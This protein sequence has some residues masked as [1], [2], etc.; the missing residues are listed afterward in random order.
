E[1]KKSTIP[2]TLAKKPLFSYTDSTLIILS[3]DGPGLA[4]L[5]IF[6]ARVYLFIL[7]VENAEVVESRK[8][9]NFYKAS[10]VG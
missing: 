9:Y 1:P 2:L 10:S 8:I 3:S 7:R 5:L 6:W 4:G